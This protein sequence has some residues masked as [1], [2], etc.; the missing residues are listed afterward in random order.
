MRKLLNKYLARF[1]L[2]VAKTYASDRRRRFFEVALA[3]KA[4]LVSEISDSLDYTVQRGPF[5]GLR[6]P[7]EGAWSDYDI[8]AKLVGAYEQQ[9]HECIEMLL[10]RRLAAVVNVGASEGYYILGF[11]MR[12]S[13]T[14]CF[15]YDID[16]SATKIL[17]EYAKLNGVEVEILSKFDCEDPLRDLS[18]EKDDCNV[19]FIYDC[20]GCEAGI[21]EFPQEAIERSLFLVELHDMFEPGVTQRLVDSLSRT[22][23][24]TLITET[25]RD[26]RDF[27]ELHQLPIL[28][29]AL[30]LD[31][32]RAEK[33]NWLFA[34]PKA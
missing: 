14:R 26:F 5:V 28:E 31:E 32:F 13:D 25:D 23:S 20:E 34:E 17:S 9:L 6:L 4:E 27:P 18:L 1:G 24:I 21:C 16:V 12:K 10:G 30:I 8:A 11:A 7:S 22:H 33:M 29:K 2:E 19:L 15:A 3:R